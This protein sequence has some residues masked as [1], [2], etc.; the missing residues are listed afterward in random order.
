MLVVVIASSWV[1]ARPLSW[2]EVRVLAANPPRLAAWATV[3][4]FTWF[5][6]RFAKPTVLIWLVV[7]WPIWVADSPESWVE[8]APDSVPGVI[9]SSWVALN[10]P[11][12]VELNSA[13][14]PPDR[15]PSC[16]VVRAWIWVELKDCRSVV[17][18]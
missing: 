6:D 14:A 4:P 17:L 3:R 13:S 11:S 7:S 16:V 18:T 5:A 8:L 2:V 15:L 10:W 9:A 12:S 1:A